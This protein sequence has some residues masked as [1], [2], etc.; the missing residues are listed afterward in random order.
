MSQYQLLDSRTVYDNGF[1]CVTEDKV[2]QPGGQDGLF[3][4]VRM[5][6]G[7]TVLPVTPDLKVYLAQ[8][9]KYSMRRDSLELMSGGIEEGESPL[10]A[11]KR[12][13]KEELG[14][15][16]KQWTPMG[17]VDPFTSVVNSRNYM[18]MAQDLESMEAQND[19]NEIIKPML[20]P[21][22]NAICMLMGGI[23]TH[24]ASCVLL[25]KAERL[26]G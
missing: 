1:I 20:V 15:A 24:S 25:L 21:L 13:L 4:L 23:I 6:D 7:A 26:L 8:E 3:G 10:D 14:L 5:R 9:Y 16:A 11:A 12:E 22:G 19:P 2:I 18:Y 17:Y